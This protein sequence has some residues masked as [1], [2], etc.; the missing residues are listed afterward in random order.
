MKDFASHS[1]KPRLCG[2]LTTDVPK[3]FLVLVPW[4]KSPKVFILEVIFLVGGMIA[5][6]SLEKQS[7][8]NIAYHTSRT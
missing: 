2:R 5:Q 3:W 4:E 8:K 7:F 1:S 6:I